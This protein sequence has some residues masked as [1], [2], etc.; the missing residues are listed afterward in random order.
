MRFLPA[1]RPRTLEARTLKHVI[2]VF[3]KYITCVGGTQTKEYLCGARNRRAGKRQRKRLEV[4]RGI[5]VCEWFLQ[6]IA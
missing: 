6:G 3:T 1:S 4:T 5:W 2:T